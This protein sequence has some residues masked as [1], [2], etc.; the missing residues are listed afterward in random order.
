MRYLPSSFK[1]GITREQMEQ[2]IAFGK[3]FELEGS[4]S[5]LE[6][7]MY[8]GWDDEADFLE[9]GVAYP[10]NEEEYAFHAMKASK[11]YRDKV[12]P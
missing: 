1:H 2:V 9:V 10:E 5:G 12:N 6:K 7:V 4:V 11:T 8:V 3:P